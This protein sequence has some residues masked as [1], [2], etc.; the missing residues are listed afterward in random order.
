MIVEYYL[1]QGNLEK[2]EHYN[3]LLLKAFPG[4]K[5]AKKLQEEIQQRRAA[6]P[7][8]PEE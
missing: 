5:A 3:K 8:K 4:F 6:I 2:A 7:S 1:K